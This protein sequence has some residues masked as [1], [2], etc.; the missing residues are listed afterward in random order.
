ME[1]SADLGGEE[2]LVF[3]PFSTDVQNGELDITPF[4]KRDD[5]GQVW[6]EMGYALPLYGRLSTWPEGYMA[7]VTG[8]VGATTRLGNTV[9]IEF[10]T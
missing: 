8:T 7:A 2:D 10:L 6:P 3:S 5:A 4:A 9:Q 1:W